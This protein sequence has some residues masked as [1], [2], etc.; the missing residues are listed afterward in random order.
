MQDELSPQ[1]VKLSLPESPY[2]Y[3][4]FDNGGVLFFT[5]VSN[6]QATLGRV[7]FYDTHLSVN[8]AISCG[9]CHKQG[10]AF[11]DNV[12]FSQ[13]FENHST[14]RNTLPIQNISNTTF[15][16]SFN[17]PSL[18]WDGR[19]NFLP[20]MVFMPML[21][22]VEMGMN[23][24]NAI[25]QKVKSLSYYNDLFL[26]AYGSDEIN[27]QNV[28]N[29]LSNF[30]SALVSGNTR[31][32]R[33]NNNLTQLTG[34]ENEGRSLFFNK[35]NCNSC[36]QTQAL[37]GYEMGGGFVNIGLDANYTDKGHQNVTQSQ[38][39]NGKFKIPNLRN[40]ALTAPYM[41]DGRFTDLTQ[42]LNHYS[43]GIA[44][45]PA[46]DPR[47]KDANGHPMRMN[48]TDHEKTAIIAF[49]NTLTDYTLITDP[50]FSNPFKAL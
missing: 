2:S 18:F 37:N 15:F 33:F 9:T 3:D 10:L 14:L 24:M 35:Y 50:K 29:A 45:S 40:I 38:S 17:S 21:N 7:L 27:A 12:K 44:D 26:K 41:H 5:N 48:I 11:S 25:V 30:V 13:G 43:S 39:D 16:N 23:D 34:L 6:N 28:G 4:T 32:D 42:V 1:Q 49:L 47:L 20:S 8:N 31:F 36:H 19:A 22:H 46:L